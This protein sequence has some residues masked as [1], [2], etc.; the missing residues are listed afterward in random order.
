MKKMG[1]SGRSM[2]ARL[3]GMNP[4]ALGGL[5]P[6]SAANDARIGLFLL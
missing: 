1:Q 2:M 6:A 4:Q 3:G 5:P